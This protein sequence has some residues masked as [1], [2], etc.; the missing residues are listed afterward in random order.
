MEIN[1]RRGRGGGEGG[2]R[3]R[4]ESENG[5]HREPQDKETR[6]RAFTH[7]HRDSHGR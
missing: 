1:K 6:L 3:Q 4:K 5:G 7:G 2:R